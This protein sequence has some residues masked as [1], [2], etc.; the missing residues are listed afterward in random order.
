MNIARALSGDR[1]IDIKVTGIRPG[2]KMHGI[3]VSE[4][5]ANHCIAR[6]DYYSIL[7]MLP[8][9]SNGKNEQPN[10][11][12]GEYSSADAVLDLDGTI[13]LLKKHRLRVEDIEAS[14]SEELLR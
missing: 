3:L 7:S 5:E 6:G 14:N 4:E 11:L 2:E 13:E 1:P 10:A 9:L 8:E 12:A